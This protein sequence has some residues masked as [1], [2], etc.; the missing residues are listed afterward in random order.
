MA[1]ISSEWGRA[2]R[3][4]PLGGDVT[5]AELARSLARIEAKLD[6]VTDDHEQRL[7]RVEHWI[8]AAGGL[9]MAGAVSGFG[10]L[11]TSIVGQ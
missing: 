3:M 8:W 10:A 5:P 1:D 9:G 11:L 2:Y 7:R 4:A 6:R